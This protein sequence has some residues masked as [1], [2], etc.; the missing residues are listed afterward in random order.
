MVDDKSGSRTEIPPKFQADIDT[1]G[2]DEKE[3]EPPEWIT[4]LDREILA[5][6][7]NSRIILTPSVIA[8]N[9]DRSRSSVSRRL[10]TLEAGEMVEKV[11]RGHYT[12]TSEG[13]ARMV[14][15]ID[16]LHTDSDEEEI[17]KT[18]KIPTPEEK[19]ELEEKGRLEE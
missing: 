15:Y 8:K 2:Y 11:E 18:I 16:I 6:L 5:L 10:N 13:Y 9:L 14:E 1:R 7:G 17:W 12:I 19:E 4:A 3:L